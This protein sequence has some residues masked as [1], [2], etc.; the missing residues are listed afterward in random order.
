MPG[1]V[2]QTRR[3]SVMIVPIQGRWCIVYDEE[4]LGSYHSP[5]AAVDDAAGGHT[6]TPSNGV[7]LGN[8]GLSDD[9]GDWE[10]L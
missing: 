1:F 9:L 5:M 10:R 3:G 6:F 4:N 2:H 8:L 7:D